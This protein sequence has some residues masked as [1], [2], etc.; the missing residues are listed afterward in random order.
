MLPFYFKYNVASL[1]LFR[2]SRHILKKKIS[3]LWILTSFFLV[4]HL[5]QANKPQASKTKTCSDCGE[6]FSSQYYLTKHKDFIM[7]HF[8]YKNASPVSLCYPFCLI[9]F[10]LFILCRRKKHLVD[11]DIIVVLEMFAKGN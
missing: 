8:F 10:S 6:R 4:V 7:F 2:K 1:H 3:F 5:K 9:F 11:I